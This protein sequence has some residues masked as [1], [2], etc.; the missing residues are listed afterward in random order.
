LVPFSRRVH[1]ADA[2]SVTQ[3]ATALRRE[4]SDV[5]TPVRINSDYSLPRKIWN[6]AWS[7]L[8]REPYVYYEYGDARFGR[9]LKQAVVRAPPDMIHL[10][11]LDV[12][13]WLPSLPIL[14]TA[15]THHNIESDLLRLH[16]GHLP[17]RVV[18]RYIKPQANLLQ[19]LERRLSAGF[20]LS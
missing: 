15:C 1:Q 9:E 11:S 8:S 13:R 7:V 2:A 14:P 17:D 6:H 10:D 5:V 19:K 16:A 12:Y 18:R 20:G 4:L 3:G